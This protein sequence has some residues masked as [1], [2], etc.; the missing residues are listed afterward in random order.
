MPKYYYPETEFVKE[1]GSDLLYNLH[2][3]K[4]SD[5]S[6]DYS[7]GKPVMVNDL[8]IKVQKSFG[9]EIPEEHLEAL[10]EHLLKEANNWLYYQYGFNKSE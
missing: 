5:G 6:F 4:K 2:H 1:A 10:R 9:S 3:N 8:V 7:K